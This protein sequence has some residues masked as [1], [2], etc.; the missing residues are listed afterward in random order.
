MTSGAV[1]PLLSLL[2]IGVVLVSAPHCG[3]GKKSSRRPRGTPQTST[4]TGA[5]PEAPSDWDGKEDFSG[6]AFEVIEE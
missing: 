1:V 2:L 3:W 6:S 5:P 4:A